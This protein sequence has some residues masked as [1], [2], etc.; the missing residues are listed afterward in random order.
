MGQNQSQKGRSAAFVLKVVGNQSKGESRGS[1]INFRFYN[2]PAG[3]DMKNDLEALR[4]K[5]LKSLSP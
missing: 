5:T 1:L 2:N 4:L 3:F